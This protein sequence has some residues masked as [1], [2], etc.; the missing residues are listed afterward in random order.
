M[1]TLVFMLSLL[2][3]ANYALAALGDGIRRNIATVSPEEQ[4]RFRDA[5]IVLNQRF[6][7]G[8][9]ADFPAGHVSY[10]FK[11][12]EIHQATHVHGG[13]AFLP[14]HRELCNRLEAMLRA[15]DPALSLH[16]WDWNTDPA[17][18]FT[19]DFMGNANG[20]AGD[21]WLNAGLYA[22]TIVGDNYRD[23]SV[24]SL[25][26]GSYPLYANP[27]DPPRTLTRNKQAG[28]PPVGQSIG[29]VFWPT[30]T[31]LMNAPTFQEFNNLM[32]GC[33]MG[34]S[35]NCAHGMAHD[36]IGGTIGNP[37]TSFRDPFVFLLHS[38]VDRLWAMWQTQPM[39]PE[40][41]DPNQVYGTDDLDPAII[42]PLQPWA[43]EAHWTATGGWPVRPWYT[44]DNQQE[45]K[46]SKA[47]SVVLPPRYDTNYQPIVPLAPWFWALF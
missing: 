36:Y 9:R 35:N 21:P 20:D 27:A 7:P 43:G 3:G 31:Q 15:V 16:Y 1:F 28:A 24:H 13:P 18:L 42:S 26:G 6:F 22:P 37:H 5:I 46:T 34:T 25:N 29:G 30:D 33:E 8:N 14:W 11:Q 32:Q 19:K 23:N 45:V 47:L 40:R 2:L 41:L 39:H 10:W 44:P 17:P 38:N 4:K 12:D